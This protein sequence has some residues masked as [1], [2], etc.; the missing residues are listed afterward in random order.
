MVEL[1][2]VLSIASVIGVTAMLSVGGQRQRNEFTQAV[3]DFETRLL[4]IANDVARGHYPPTQ[5][6]N[7]ACLA[8]PG[9]ISFSGPATVEQ[10]ASRD[11]VFAGRAIEFKP[12]SPAADAMR[13][14]T[15]AAR[16]LDRQGNPVNRLGPPALVN[17]DL[18]TVPNAQDRISYLHGLRVRSVHS[19]IATG[20]GSV[21][22]G[23]IVFMTGFA[24]QV[25]SG[26]RFTGGPP[27]FVYNLNGT[28]LGSSQTTVRTQA[29][30]PANYV[31]PGQAGIR[32]CLEHGPGG[33]R[34]LVVIGRSGGQLTTEAWLEGDRATTDRVCA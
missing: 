14:Q 30:N 28:S 19:D 2:I 24:H 3:R 9:G 8:G 21:A 16:R 23:T 10:G 31:A 7:Q 34:A 20:P 13:V 6:A 29:R 33:R 1:L 25:S 17:G 4:D 26:L 5:G 22:P 15:I 27:T 12:D 32:I 18:D 11:C